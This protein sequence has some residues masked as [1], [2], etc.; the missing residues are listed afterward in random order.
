MNG[1]GS[2]V[3]KGFKGTGITVNLQT[4]ASVQVTVDMTVSYTAPEST[5]LT[6]GTPITLT[7]SSWN[8]FTITEVGTYTLTWESTNN[9]YVEVYLNGVFASNNETFTKSETDSDWYFVVRVGTIQPSTSTTDTDNFTFT[10]TPV[11]E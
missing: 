10:F 2:I 3:V 4:S 5:A 1:T 7:E 8:Y 11:S 6:S 9:T